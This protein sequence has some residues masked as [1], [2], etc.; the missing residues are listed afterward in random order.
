MIPLDR[1]RNRRSLSALLGTRRPAEAPIATEPALRRLSVSELAIV[2]AADHFN[3]SQF[4][5]TVGGI[6]KSLG[7][8]RV[9]IVPL[10]GIN[11][12]IVITVAWEISW[13]Q[14]RLTPESSQPVRL[15]GRGHELSEVDVSYS[16]WNAQMVDDGRIV[17]DIAGA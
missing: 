12:E 1:R 15:E 13:Y 4:R 2:D 5:R 7:A 6:A 9:S 8:P 16:S 14:Y 11:K 17:P 10:S 3:S